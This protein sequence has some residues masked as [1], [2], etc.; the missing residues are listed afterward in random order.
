MDTTRFQIIVHGIVALGTINVAG[1]V[2]FFLAH[3]DNANIWFG[4]KNVQLLD[5]CF[6][7]YVTV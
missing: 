7:L 4:K 2:F 5:V 1:F 6:N 3:A